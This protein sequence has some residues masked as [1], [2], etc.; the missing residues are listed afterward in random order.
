LTG[1]NIG[2]L[3]VYLNIGSQRSRAF[4]LQDQTY[5]QWSLAT[6]NIGRYA[7]PFSISF[8]GFKSDKVNG[9]LAIDDI[10]FLS[11]TLIYQ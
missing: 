6:I 10:S 4:R 8:E 5:T 3:D 7:A 2:M 1:K 11:K 9:H